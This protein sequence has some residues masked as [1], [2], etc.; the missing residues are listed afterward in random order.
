MK[1]EVRIYNTLQDMKDDAPKS[2]ISGIGTEE[3][4]EQIKGMVNFIKSRMLPGYATG[5]ESSL[6]RALLTYP[7]LVDIYFTGLNQSYFY[8]FKPA[9]INTFTTDFTPQGLALN[10]GGKPSFINITMTVTEAQIHTRGDFE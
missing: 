8:F 3:E 2:C 9:M 1:H 10:K 6:G 7:D 5:G 4:A